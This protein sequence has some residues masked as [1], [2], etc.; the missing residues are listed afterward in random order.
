[1]DTLDTIRHLFA[2]DEWANHESLASLRQGTADALAPPPPRALRLMAHI[3]A[4]EWLWLSRILGQPS[5]LPVWPELDAAECADRMGAV[6]SRWR[7]LL[8][9][10]DDEALARE[11]SYVNSKGEQWTNS[12]RDILLHTV[13][14]SV[15]HRGQLASDVRASGSEPAYTDYIEAVR[16]GMLVE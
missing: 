4:V 6:E 2:Y 12:V 13:M 11:V 1:M 10:L 16:R 9:A 15:Y 14:H 5:P 7:A 3:V 8:A